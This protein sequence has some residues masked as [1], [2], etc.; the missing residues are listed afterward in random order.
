MILDYLPASSVLSLAYTCS[1]FRG[2][3]PLAIEDVFSRTHRNTFK[4]FAMLEE[5]RAVY[6][7]LQKRDK[8]RS[9]SR[10]SWHTCAVCKECYRPS[11]FKIAAIRH[12]EIGLTC[13]ICEGLTWIC[14]HKIWS[15]PQAMDIQRNWQKSQ[16][17]IEV[18][19]KRTWSFNGPC[20]YG[21]HFVWYAEDCILQWYPVA[22]L[23]T[24][25]CGD[26]SSTY[27]HNVAS[28]M[29]K[30]NVPV[31][32]HNTIQGLST[33]IDS[34][35]TGNPS[36]NCCSDCITIFD[37]GHQSI[38]NGQSLAY[39]ET[40]SFLMT[41]LD[42]ACAHMYLTFSSNVLSTDTTVE[43]S[44]FG[45]EL[46]CA[47]EDVAISNIDLRGLALPDRQWALPAWRTRFKTSLIS[48]PIIAPW[49]FLPLNFASTSQ[50]LMAGGPA[51]SCAIPI[52]W[53][54]N[55]NPNKLE[56]FTIC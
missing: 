40:T 12:P 7:A 34:L 30:L 20:R 51:A 37:L 17:V 10:F 21:K 45:S 32:A 54:S 6:L 25:A 49:S 38:G 4:A 29:S 55:I 11:Y 16:S 31:C 53:E 33:A 27:R 1:R 28:Y 36:E 42:D 2:I 22:I 15:F 39:I 47:I 13:L 23:E 43:S 8:P 3:S 48:T 5:E 44:E 56:R 24:A 18:E 14:P 41:Y 19:G 50:D 26:Q 46:M 9:W 52:L 35:C